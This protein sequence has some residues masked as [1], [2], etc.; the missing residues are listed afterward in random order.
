[1][2]ILRTIPRAF[3]LACL[4]ALLTRALCAQGADNGPA[5]DFLYGDRELFPSAIVCFTEDSPYAPTDKDQ[6]GD[7][8]G[9]ISVTIKAPTDD[10]PVRITFSETP[11]FDESHIACRLPKAGTVYR[12]A[13]LVRYRAEKL[14][15]QKQPLANLIIHAVIE[16]QGETTEIS[17]KVVVHSV[18]DAIM[19]YRPRAGPDGEQDWKADAKYLLAAYVNENNP[20]IDQRVTR[21]ALDKGY[22]DAFEGYQRDGASVRKEV[23]AI[24]DTLRDF[25]FKYTSFKEY[26]AAPAHRGGN[27][28]LQGIRLVGDTLESAQANGA[29]TVLTLASIFRKLSIDNVIFFLPKKQVLLGVYTEQGRKKAASLIVLDPRKLG[30]EEF[31]ASVASGT[32]IFNPVKDSLIFGDGDDQAKL[33]VRAEHFGYLAV[34]IA[35]ARLNGILPIPE[36]RRDFHGA[37]RDTS[38]DH[39]HSP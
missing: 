15:A 33:R 17:T 4:G 20:W 27:V 8:Q 34:D 9:V 21:H 29:E 10:C 22:V 11:F 1:M 7:P 36:V 6:I 16:M 30:Y 12:I 5:F 35:D 28:R 14:A 24:Y 18:N 13:P 3:R 25:G 32:D 37:L 19:Q 2:P 26:S 38:G 23:K 31:D 39:S